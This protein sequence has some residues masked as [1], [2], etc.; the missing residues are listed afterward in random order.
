M[1][2]GLLGT[3]FSLLLIAALLLAGCGSTQ[4]GQN[5]PNQAGAPSQPQAQPA[6]PT[7]TKS[8]NQTL[9]VG[10]GGDSVTL[11]PIVATDGESFKVTKNIYD[12]LVKYEDTNTNVIPGLADSWD[13]SKDGLT[14]TFKLHQGIKF[15]DGTDFN[16]DAVVFNFERWMDKSNPYHN[17]EGFTYY[18][19]MFNG[20]K[21]DKNH[22]IKEVKAA[23]PYTVVFTLNQPTSP[24]LNNLGM[25]AFAI[26]SPEAIKKYGDKYNENPVGTG[27]FIFKEWKRSDTITLEKNPNYW[28][29]GLPKLDKV[30]F[31]VIPE[32]S[33]RLTAL[34]SGEI[35][36]MDGLNP[37]DA[38]TVE[39]NQELQLLERPSMNVGYFTFHFKKKPFDNLKVR[40]AIAHAVNKPAIVQAFYAGRAIPAVN[41]MPPSVWGYNDQIKDRPYD[42]EKAKQLL[43][44]AGYPKGFSTTLWAMP[45]P[46][47]YMP[48]GQKIAEAL[49][50]DLKKIG[51]DAKI[52]S[53]E[54]ATYL[55]KVKKGEQDMYLLGWTGD[56][57][58][59]DN[60]LNV[61]FNPSNRSRYDNKEVQDLL[62]KAQSEVDKAKRIEM[63]KKAQE[64]LFNDVAMIPLAHSTPLLAIKK[65][66]TGYVPHPTGSE[67]V[68]NVEIK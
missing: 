5:T 67:S 52:V 29:Q 8:G 42:L 35:D 63:Y 62:V 65:G 14:Y 17:K 37:D 31:K 32:N 1:K 24:F 13:I 15:H 58:D 48:E 60:F 54:W 23:D 53:M 46:R 38:K 55:D 30:V 9:I 28:Q 34:T 36:V 6:A 20:Y 3:S 27:P 50:Q 22:V 33:A 57:G 26:A 25:P 66:V 39:E 41:D 43:A 45:V 16:A 47:P 51:I 64:M 19:D 68:V 4:T 44:E 12:T 40:E 7:E 59:P 61:L 21:G 11:D 49:Q 56:N 2:K 10:R 18:S